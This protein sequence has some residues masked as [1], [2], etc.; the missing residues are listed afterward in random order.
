[1][2]NKLPSRK[3]TRLKG[4]DY[5][6]TGYY[7]ITICT[8]GRGNILGDVVGC[9]AFIAPPFVELSEYGLVVDKYIN[10]ISSMY[11]EFYVDKYIIMPNHIHMILVKI[12]FDITQEHGVMKASRPTSASISSVIRSLK[13]M[14]TKEIKVRVWQT[15]FHDHI[16]RDEKDYHR[17]WQY[18]D[19]NPAKWQDDRYYTI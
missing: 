7:F 13:T 11:G 18:I 19:T 8:K 6:S 15:S 1:M 10:R 2:Q 12:A 16:I 14:I 4:Y 3:Q 9:D 17:I 5:T